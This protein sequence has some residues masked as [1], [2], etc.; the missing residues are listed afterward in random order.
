MA[1]PAP[2]AFT[3]MQFAYTT[4]KNATDMAMVIDAMDLLYS[5]I[6]DGFCIVSS[7]S[8]FTRLASRIRENGLTVYGFGQTK[9]P[10][11]FR[12]ACDKFIFT[13]N[14]SSDDTVAEKSVPKPDANKQKQNKIK[15]DTK[16][17]NLIR[18]AIDVHSDDSGWASLGPIGSYINRVSPDFDVKNYGFSKLSD[19]IKFIDLFETQKTGT[20]LTVRKKNTG[21]LLTAYKLT[22]GRTRLRP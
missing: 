6:F 18:D 21:A 9:T 1:L 12:K 22:P 3:V 14:L 10:E 19:L 11:P 17:M 2:S 16:L 20:R 4:G 5:K 8:D 7:D 15:S 13:E